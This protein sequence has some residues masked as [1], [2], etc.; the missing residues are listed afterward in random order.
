MNYDLYFYCIIRKEKKNKCRTTA[1][2]NAARSNVYYTTVG[3]SSDGEPGVFDGSV[4]TFFI[5]RAQLSN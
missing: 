4:I 3:S 5:V 1:R 2:L